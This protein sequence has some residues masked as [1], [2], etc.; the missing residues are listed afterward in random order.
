VKKLAVAAGIAPPASSAIPEWAEPQKRQRR[1]A[2]P[3]SQRK[4]LEQLQRDVAT[5]RRKQDFRDQA[6]AWA[7]VISI[8]WLVRKAHSTGSRI[9]VRINKDDGTSRPSYDLM[10][11][12]T[13]QGERTIAADVRLL[14]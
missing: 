9:A 11:A 8:H 13:G 6:R 2:S 10:V 7:D 3:E 1:E 5:Y 14:Q 12:E 4:A